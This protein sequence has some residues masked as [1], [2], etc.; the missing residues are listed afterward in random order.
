MKPSVPKRLGCLLGAVQVFAHESWRSDQDLAWFADSD[1]GP[2]VADQTDVHFGTGN[3][4]R[5]G[6]RH[7][8][9]VL[10]RHA[11]HEPCLRQAVALDPRE[12]PP[13]YEVG[14]KLCGYTNV[15]REIDL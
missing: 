8:I 5:A 7:L 14:V 3:A 2:V 12:T 13:V 1:F 4:N 6:P 15:E 9:G 11:D 10:E